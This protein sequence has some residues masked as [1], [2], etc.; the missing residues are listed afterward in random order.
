MPNKKLKL[1]KSNYRSYPGY[2]VKK[3]SSW[4]TLKTRPLFQVL[5]GAVICLPIVFLMIGFFNQ[6]DKSHLN[7]Q[8][9]KK[10]TNV[11][12][13]GNVFKGVKNERRN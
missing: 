2:R 5:A 1:I 10:Q 13:N 6:Y 7:N 4:E 12:N 8:I 11:Q 3:S 9:A